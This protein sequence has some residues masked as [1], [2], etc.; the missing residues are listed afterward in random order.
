VTATPSTS[1]PPA[2]TANGR[3]P[4][5]FRICPT[6]CPRLP[7]ACIPVSAGTKTWAR[8][9]RIQLATPS[10]TRQVTGQAA[11]GGDNQLNHA[12]LFSSGVMQTWA[13]WGELE[14]RSRAQC[15]WTGRGSAELAGWYQSRVPV[16][17][18][19][20]HD[21]NELVTGWP[22]CL[23]LASGITTTGK[24]PPARVAQV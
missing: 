9:R 6:F 22:D 1:A 21:L 15:R 23:I 7:P 14:Q 17:R 8:S 16:C 10:T 2:S 19:V 20:M 18:R 13:R 3:D 5:G 24:F 4:D 12:F 11:I